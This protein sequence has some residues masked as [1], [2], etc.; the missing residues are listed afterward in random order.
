MANFVAAYRSWIGVVFLVTGSILATHAAL[1]PWGGIRGWLMN[2]RATRTR[3]ERLHDL[4]PDETRILVRYIEGNTRTQNLDIKSGVVSG[5]EEAGIIY[6]AADMGDLMRGFAYNI[7][8][9]AREYL[10]RHRS[11]LEIAGASATGE[12]RRL[13]RR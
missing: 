9:W 13:T 10:M 2:L 5:L 4:T 7:Q 8:P 1:V 6:R 11:L 12:A 3:R